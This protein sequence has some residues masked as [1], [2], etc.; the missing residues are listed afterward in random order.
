MG[1]QMLV[2]RVVSLASVLAVGAGEL[3]LLVVRLFM[4][5]QGF[6]TIEFPGAFTTPIS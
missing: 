6:S 3:F 2:E 5:L 4:R 1:E